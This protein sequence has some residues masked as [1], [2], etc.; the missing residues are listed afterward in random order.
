MANNQFGVQHLESIKL[1]TYISGFELFRTRNSNTYF[2]ILYV[3]YNM[4]ESY[5]FKIQNDVCY[6]F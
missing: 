2:F 4:F 3:V 5:L 6:I 1:L